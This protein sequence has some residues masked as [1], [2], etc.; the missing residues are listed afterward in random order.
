MAQIK[1]KEEAREATRGLSSRI[2]LE[3]TS[4]R[5]GWQKGPLLLTFSAENMNW[6]ELFLPIRPDIIFNCANPHLH[7]SV[8]TQMVTHASHIWLSFQQATKQAR[9]FFLIIFCQQEFLLSFLDI[10]SVKQWQRLCALTQQQ[11]FDLPPLLHL[12]LLED[13]LDL[14]VYS[15]GPLLVLGQAAHAGAAAPPPAARHGSTRL[16]MKDVNPQWAANKI[17]LGSK[18]TSLPFQAFNEFSSIPGNITLKPQ[19]IRSQSYMWMSSRTNDSGCQWTP[20]VRNFWTFNLQERS[21]RHR[22]RLK[23]FTFE[24]VRQTPWSSAGLP[25][26][27]ISISPTSHCTCG[28]LVQART[29]RPGFVDTD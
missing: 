13:P 18:I 11:D 25:R 19:L 12:L 9:Q 22:W 10:T 1:Q 26:S 24:L 17:T 29:L 4:V 3:I 7:H 6:K 8:H 27:V 14:L 23:F 5:W 21:D 20:R 2:F 15:D 28:W 16:Q